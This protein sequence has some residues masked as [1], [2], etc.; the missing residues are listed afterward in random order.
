[1]KNRS[2]TFTTYTA[3]KSLVSDAVNVIYPTR[4]GSVWI[5]TDNGLSVYKS[6]TWQTYTTKQGLAGDQVKAMVSDGRG[7]LWV[8]T[9]KGISVFDG[10]KWTSY[11]MAMDKCLSWNDTKALAYD[12][13]TK[14]IWAAVGEKDV[15]SFNG[16]SWSVFM[17]IADG[18]MSIM[19]DSQ[20]RVWFG[21]ATGLLKFNGDEWISDQ[22]KLGVPAIMVTQMYRDNGGNLWFASEKGVI[23]V[24]NPYPF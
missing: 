8:G 19:T 2:G 5:G 22:K 12:P 3:G 20:S 23:F 24:T 14:T 1:M 18:I 17:E 11:T 21:M 13:R 10:A 6:G 7:A 9:A 15:N 4:D 16:T